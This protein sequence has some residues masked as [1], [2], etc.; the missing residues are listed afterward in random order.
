MFLVYKS[1]KLFNAQVILDQTNHW[2]FFTKTQN[3]M[4]LEH[5]KI[6]INIVHNSKM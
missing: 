3:D 6:T 4:Y 1:D 5:I 2:Y